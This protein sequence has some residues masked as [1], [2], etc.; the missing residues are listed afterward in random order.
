MKHLVSVII[1]TLD[2]AHM[3]LP[4]LDAIAAN[5]TPHE[6]IVAD[7]G[8]SDK[9][10]ELA[11]QTGA[12]LVRATERNRAIQM[13]EGRGLARGEVPLFLHADTLIAPVALARIANALRERQVAW[14]SLREA[15]L[16]PVSIPTDDVFACGTSRESLR[17]V[18]W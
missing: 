4:T 5:E 10:D 18:P 1:P 3:I 8:S 6:V 16:V 12:R 13:N 7:G 17:L 2:E 9:T 11:E 15:V 14:R